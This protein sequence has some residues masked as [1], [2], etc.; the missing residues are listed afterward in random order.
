LKFTL[1][2]ASR[3]DKADCSLHIEDGLCILKGLKPACTTLRVVPHIKGLY[4]PHLPPWSI[5]LTP[6][7]MPMSPPV[8][9]PSM[10]PPTTNSATLTSQR[11]ARWSRK[12]CLRYRNRSSEQGSAKTSQTSYKTYGKVL[13]TFNVSLFFDTNDTFESYKPYEAWVK[14]QRILLVSRALGQI[15]AGNSQ[16]RP[17]RRT[18]F[19]KLAP[20]VT[21]H[22]SPQFQRTQQPCND[23]CRNS[24]GSDLKTQDLAG[25]SSPSRA[26][27]G[28][29][30][31]LEA[32]GQPNQIFRGS[33]NGA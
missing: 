20:F 1:V 15:E 23:Y 12:G 33:S 29:I 14:A 19:S 9:Y 4:L 25:S 3:L 21:T 5:L 32:T 27:P 2:S 24:Y 31:P 26:L 17:S 16:V 6:N 11:P 7:S 22:D 30:M 13:P 10:T 8:P 18:K 28:C